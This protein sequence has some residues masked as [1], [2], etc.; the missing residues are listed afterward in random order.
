ME[1]KIY[2]NN[3]WGSWESVR[4][5]EKN[6]K[7]IGEHVDNIYQEILKVNELKTELEKLGKPLRRGYLLYGKPGNGKTTRIKALANKLNKNICVLAIDKEITNCRL[8]E[9]IL[10][11]PA[12]SIL[13]IEDID[14]LKL[15]QTNQTNNEDRH[16]IE[17]STFLNILDGLYT[18]TGLL[19]FATA[20]NYEK[21]DK[22]IIRTGRFDRHIEFKSP[23]NKEH[24]SYADYVEEKVRILYKV[25]AR[26]PPNLFGR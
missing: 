15:V 24:N 10:R 21:I 3:T 16:K 14:R 26:G 8:I 7:F 20:N 1:P 23:E 11:V 25:L 12:Q 4:T 9:S 2:T 17:L 19:V 13:L 5:L 6:V 18:P 22:A